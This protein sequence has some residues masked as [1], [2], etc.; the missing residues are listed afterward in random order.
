MSTGKRKQDAYYEEVKNAEKIQRSERLER[1]NALKAALV[2]P[3][4][5]FPENDV[6]FAYGS[7]GGETE[8][9]LNI[10]LGAEAQTIISSR[11]IN[12][13]L[14]QGNLGEEQLTVV[15]RSATDLFH[16]LYPQFVIDAF[17]MQVDVATMQV[18]V[19]TIQRDILKGC[20]Y[21][22]Q[23]LLSQD[24]TTGEYGRESVPLN[25]IIQ[26]YRSDPDGSNYF[27]DEVGPLTYPVGKS[28]SPSSSVAS[29]PSR[30]VR[31]I[32]E[33]KEDI[34]NGDEM[35][36][37]M[38]SVDAIRT[39]LTNE[40]TS[41][42]YL[43]QHLRLW[44]VKTTAPMVVF[45]GIGGASA[46]PEF[47]QITEGSVQ[48]ITLPYIV[49]TTYDL[50]VAKRFG[51]STRQILCILFDTGVPLPVVS[52]ATSGQTEREILLN[53]G[54]TLQKVADPGN[55]GEYTYHYYRLHGFVL[56]TREQVRS[57]IDQATEV[58]AEKL[59]L[60]AEGNSSVKR[61]TAGVTQ[62]MDMMPGGAKKRRSRRKRKGHTVNK[63]NKHANKKNKNKKTKRNN[64]QRKTY[65]I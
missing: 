42:F 36:E 57:K 24:T 26:S 1:R 30:I 54:A 2:K 27:E 62:P 50:D 11:E 48:N 16:N 32:E 53:N 58:W 37:R 23:V 14:G 13:Y 65:K 40:I 17:S 12:D 20:L 22:T 46:L 5:V 56:P 21:I 47:Q 29:I 55:D 4:I 39:L 6:Y 43:T 19:A 33:W 49:S 44:P 45:T 18:N 60:T 61:Q 31:Q 64:K 35:D 52:Q 51:G 25:T 7:T 8:V 3:Q 10:R 9:Q 34:E 15:Q 41:Q 59:G 28:I 63:K 38:P